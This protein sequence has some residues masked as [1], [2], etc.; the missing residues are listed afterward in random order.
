MQ[1]C[2]VLGRAFQ[3]VLRILTRFRIVF[4]EMLAGFT[5]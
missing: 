4:H 2:A 5:N 1:E 3:M